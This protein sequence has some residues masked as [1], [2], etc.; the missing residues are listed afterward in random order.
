MLT[1]NKSH[2]TK[3]VFIPTTHH[4]AH[5]VVHQS[6]HIQFKLLRRRKKKGF[7]LQSFLRGNRKP[8]QCKKELEIK[9]SQPQS[10]LSIFQISL[11]WFCFRPSVSLQNGSI[12][13]L[14]IPISEIYLP[15]ED[16]FLQQPHNIFSFTTRSAESLGPLQE[17]SLRGKESRNQL[18]PQNQPG[19]TSLCGLRLSD[20]QKP[21]QLIFKHADA[22]NSYKFNKQTKQ[23]YALLDLLP[24]F[25]QLL[26]LPSGIQGLSHT[27]SW[28]ILQG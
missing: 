21:I 6:Y 5:C 7:G 9:I 10:T 15:S 4:G 11:L 22:L 13:Q 12:L 14:E 26:Q 17:D 18:P 8:P 1:N 16:G 20:Q 3:R 28:P 23:S 24:C 2:F 25:H 19:T 27:N